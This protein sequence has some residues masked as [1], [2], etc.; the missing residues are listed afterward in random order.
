M[1]NMLAHIQLNIYKK[2][3]VPRRLSINYI[4]DIEKGYITT[5]NL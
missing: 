5:T 1:Q 3:K 4:V 2:I